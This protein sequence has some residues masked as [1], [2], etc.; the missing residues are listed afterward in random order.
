MS[1]EAQALRYVFLAERAAAHSS[2]FGENNIN[3][4]RRRHHSDVTLL[5]RS[6]AALS[7][8]TETVQ[9]INGKREEGV[10][11]TVAGVVGSGVMGAGIAATLLMAR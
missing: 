4:S 6:P 1:L 2:P 8:D 10:D 7:R 9:R 11:V 3:K 5:G